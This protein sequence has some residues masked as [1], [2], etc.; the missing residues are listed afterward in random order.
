M[1]EILLYVLG[2]VYATGSIYTAVVFWRYGLENGS[3]KRGPWEPV[4][5]AI[6]LALFWPVIMGLMYFSKEKQ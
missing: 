1:T 5:A 6:T 4:P 2:L 3:E